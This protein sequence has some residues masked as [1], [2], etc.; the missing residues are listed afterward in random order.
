MK[1]KGKN[2]YELMETVNERRERKGNQVKGKIR[3]SV[4]VE[5]ERRKKMKQQGGKQAM[6]LGRME[7][8]LGLSFSFPFFSRFI[9]LI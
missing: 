8:D 2:G 1:I 4:M 6:E 9:C 5:T 3:E 7:L